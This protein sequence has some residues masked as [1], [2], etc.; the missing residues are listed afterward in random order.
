MSI[1]TVLTLVILIL[2]ALALVRWVR[3]DRFRVVQ[4]PAWFE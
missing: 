1:A 3:H 4:P 2:G